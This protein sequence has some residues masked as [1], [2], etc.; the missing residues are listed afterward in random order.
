KDAEDKKP[1]H[2]LLLAKNKKGYKNLMKLVSIAHISGFYYKLRIDMGLL[3]EYCEGL[4]ATSSCLNGPLAENILEGNMGI[5]EEKAK[6]FYEIFKDDFY[7]EIQHH[8][9]ISDQEKLNKG[10][11]ELSKTLGIPLVAT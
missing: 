4:I 7:L 5:A 11:V 9:N 10:I 1:Y 2:L 3:E 6:K 8:P